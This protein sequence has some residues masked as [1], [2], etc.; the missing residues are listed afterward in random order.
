MAEHFQGE[1]TTNVVGMILRQVGGPL[2][3]RLA[4][5][6]GRINSGCDCE[7]CSADG[8]TGFDLTSLL[9]SGTLKQVRTDSHR[10]FQ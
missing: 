2:N 10:A 9:M 7:G 6:L 3:D 1:V 8:D 5:A 4:A